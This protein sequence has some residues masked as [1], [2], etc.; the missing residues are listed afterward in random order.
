MAE[1]IEARLREAFDV[2]QLRLVNESHRHTRGPDS[3]WNV[4]LVTTAF[5]GQARLAR[6]RAVYAALGEAVMGR[7]HSVTMRTLTPQEWQDAGGQVDN[8]A[9]A[10][11]GG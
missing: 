7:I 10:C 1:Q 3:H 4:V 2:D 5:E 6:Q 11:Q 9:P 8:P